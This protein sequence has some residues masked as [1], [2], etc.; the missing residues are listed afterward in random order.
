MVSF[1]EALRRTADGEAH[2]AIPETWTQG[3]TAFG[4]LVAGLAVRAA[5][6]LVAPA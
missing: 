4:G 3:R 5:W 6:P 2:A 1:A